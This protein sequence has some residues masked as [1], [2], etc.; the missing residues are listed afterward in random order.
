MVSILVLF[1]RSKSRSPSS[2][3]LVGLLLR[4]LL[5]DIPFKSLN[6]TISN[7]LLSSLKFNGRKK[8]LFFKTNFYR[9]R[10]ALFA[11][12]GYSHDRLL[13]F[14]KVI[15]IFVLVFEFERTIY[16]L[17]IR[18][19]KSNRT[20]KMNRMLLQQFQAQ[21]VS[22]VSHCVAF[23]CVPNPTNSNS[24]HPSL[25]LFHHHHHHHHLPNGLQALSVRCL[26]TQSLNAVKKL[27]LNESRSSLLEL[28]AAVG[29]QSVRNSRSYLPKRKRGWVW[30]GRKEETDHDR[31]GLL[32]AF[33]TNAFL[34]L[35]TT[36]FYFRKGMFN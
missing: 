36:I 22:K 29:R 13:F 28:T 12:C 33:Y 26:N 15:F 25:L 5:S 21:A 7:R 9:R 6:P 16:R 1:S 14:G 24:N 4:L 34:V 2:P 31:S 32:L 27:Y 18:E 20:A 35:V 19:T 17:Q 10:C 23:L 11:R 8:K 30:Q 3:L